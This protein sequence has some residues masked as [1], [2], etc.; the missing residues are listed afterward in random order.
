MVNLYKLANT[1]ARNANYEQILRILND[2]LQ[3]SA[4]H[5]GFLFGG[6]PDFL[7]DP[8]RGLYCYAALQ[9]RLAENTFATNGLVDYSGPVLR[10]ANLSQEDL[11]LLLHNL[12]HVQ[13]AGDPTAYLLPDAGAAPLHG[14]LLDAIGDA[15]FRTPRNTIKAFLDSARRPRAEP[16]HGLGR[17]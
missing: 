7:L 13:A 12:R 3:G 17:S 9:S 1:Q 11:Y 5:L 4:A 16:R 2:S 8:R 10:L 14:A 6:T 15:Y